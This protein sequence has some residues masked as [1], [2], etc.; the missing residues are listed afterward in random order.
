[1]DIIDFH[2][3]NHEAS[4]ALISVD[5]REFDPLPGKW[6]SVGYHPWQD[7]A[8]LTEDDFDL[9]DSCA[10]HA[11]VLAI[12]ET[13]M[14]ALRGCGLDIQAQV[15]E[16]HLRLAADLNKPAIIHCV[17]TAQNILAVRR[18]AGLTTVPMVIHGFRGNE[19]VAQTLLKAGCY[20]SFGPRFN[21]AAL[22]ATPTHRLFIESDDSSTPIREVA[23][24]VA[25][26]LGISPQEVESIVASNASTLL[27]H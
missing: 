13:G 4:R 27:Q 1:M 20:L 18:K 12:G 19:H 5:P 17:R 2:T 26:V 10:R 8:S 3:H 22:Q 24:L 9:L 11:Q 23:S 25:D 15:T 14:D 16:R 21:P 6:S 7:V